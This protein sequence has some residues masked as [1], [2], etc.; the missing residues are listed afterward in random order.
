MGRFADRSFVILFI[1]VLVGLALGPN[2]LPRLLAQ[3]IPGFDQG[4]PCAW[5]RTGTDR[6]FHQS[7]LGRAADQPI[8]LSLRVSA[9]PT[10]PDGFLTM[11]ITV[12][13]NSLGT[14]PFVF[15]PQQVIVGDS[16][17][18]GLGLIFTPQT[19]LD[20]GYTRPSDTGT[21]PEANI[22]VLQPRQSCIYEAD[23]PAGNVL[24]D[25][26]VRTGN[27]EVRAFYRSNGPG[28]VVPDPATPATPIYRDQGLTRNYYVESAEVRIG[29]A[30]QP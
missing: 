16:G 29:S 7:L 23:F 21:F 11:T 20:L 10:K 9:L 6:A 14:V 26:T 3:A 17:S 24:I 15:N 30:G 12:T 27:A 18:S 4:V 1:I 19:S 5:L 28:Q 8:Q 2:V 22:R 13:N 25:P